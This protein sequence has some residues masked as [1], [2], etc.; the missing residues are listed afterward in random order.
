MSTYPNPNE[1][2]AIM[3]KGILLRRLPDII[4]KNLLKVTY[5]PCIHGD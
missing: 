4:A 2:S 1:S 3:S 5:K